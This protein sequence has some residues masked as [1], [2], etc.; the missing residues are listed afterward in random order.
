[1][2]DK[3]TAHS[4][5]FPSAVIIFIFMYLSLYNLIHKYSLLSQGKSILLIIFMISEVRYIVS[6]IKIIINRISGLEMTKRDQLRF[7]DTLMQAK[8]IDICT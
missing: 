5:I 1:M 2:Q 4:T 6:V 8:V 3:Y 7:L